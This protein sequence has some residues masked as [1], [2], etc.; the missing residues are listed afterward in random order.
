MPCAMKMVLQF[1]ESHKFCFVGPE[2]GKSHPLLQK[3]L[4]LCSTGGGFDLVEHHRLG[5]LAM[6]KPET[7]LYMCAFPLS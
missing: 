2:L 1:M 6:F 5:H 3:V 7:A 4:F